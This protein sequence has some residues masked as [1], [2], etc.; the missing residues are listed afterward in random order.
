MAAV[1]VT[2]RVMKNPLGRAS[3]GPTP[4]RLSVKPELS[5]NADGSRSASIDTKGETG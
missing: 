2:S 4:S 1:V 5:M 3:I